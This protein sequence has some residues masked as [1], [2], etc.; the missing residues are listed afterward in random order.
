[1]ARHIKAA[2][3]EIDMVFPANGKQFTLPELQGYV[4]GYI[5]LVPRMDH[6]NPP[7]DMLV[8]EDGRRM[9]LSYNGA[10]STLAQQVIV[11]DALLLKREEW[12]TPEE[13]DA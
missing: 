11:G 6:L 13:E 4:G 12:D 3:G 5:E 1:M 7:M 9:E 10:A 2:T 8:N